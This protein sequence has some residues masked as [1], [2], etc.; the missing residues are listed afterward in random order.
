[1]TD[2]PSLYQAPVSA[3]KFTLEA[4]ASPDST[5]QLAPYGEFS[6]DLVDGIL[7]GAATFAEERL[8]PLNRSGDLQ[9]CEIDSAGK[10]TLPAGFRDAYRSF[11]EDGWHSAPFAAK[12]GG[13]G[14]PAA[15][16]A[17]LQEIWHSANLSFAL[18]PLL[19]Q[20]AVHVLA[21]YGD[22]WQKQTIL[23][24]LVSGEWSGTMCL[25]EPQAGSDVGAA[26][27]RAEPHG[28]GSYR[29]KGSK[30]FISAGDHDASDNIIH[31]V[32]ARLPDAPEGTKGLS[33]FLIPKRMVH[34]DGS[35]GAHNDLHAVNLE[36]KLGMHGSPTITLA[37]G[38]KDGAIGYLL[39]EPHQGMKAMFVMMNSARLAVGLEGLG[40]AEAAT[41]TARRYAEERI[42][43]RRT[44]STDKS[45]VSIDQHPDV[46]RM[47]AFME[48]HTQALRALSAFA[49][50][51]A[52]TASFHPDETTRRKAQA[53]LDLLT[54]LAK[55]HTTNLAFT[56]A[57]EAIQVHGGAGYIEE[58][59]VAQYLRDIRVAMIYEGTN[60][61]QALDLAMRKIGGDDGAALAAL[62]SEIETLAV[63]LG[64]QHDYRL[65]P[66]G[67]QLST[68]VAH[69]RQAGESLLA[70][71][72]RTQNNH[73]GDAPAAVSAVP[74]LTLLGLLL[75]AYLLAKG[76][77]HAASLE[78]QGDTRF[79][80]AFLAQ[81]IGLARFFL[82]DTLLDTA[83]LRERVANGNLALK[84]MR[85]AQPVS[86]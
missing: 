64:N 14:V 11:V 15:L 4:I 80:K 58:T 60:G 26:R 47:L 17:A 57:S 33:L 52:D 18:I 13:M 49:A 70:Q 72:Y 48:S 9:G 83:S 50:S 16:N 40:I 1:M 76:A 43:G 31:M 86:A 7:Q 32:L 65:L 28:D 75:E 44:S 38:D 12:H 69:T 6:E 27:T 51:A 67:N 73:E 53:R 66:L 8:A 79:S 34:Q 36:H 21:E 78:K 22:D 45:S 68:A 29:I 41:Q 59:G 46:Q 56:L 24:K 61:I 77:E 37:L 81:Q 23:P 20:S 3:L 55:A 71:I 39:G 85:A 5:R 10:V 35:L 2:S 54:P 25:T 42:Q 63:T 82:S 74:F 19:T 30:I 62:L 84:V